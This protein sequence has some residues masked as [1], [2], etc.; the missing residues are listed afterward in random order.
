MAIDWVSVWAVVGP[1]VVG[2]GTWLKT[3]KPNQAKLDAAVSAAKAE[4]A[5]SGAA[6]AVAD[7]EGA[8]YKRLTDR[9]N[10][11]EADVSR[12]NTQLRAA[13]RH[14]WQLETIMR[15]AGMEPPP[16]EEEPV[17]AGGTD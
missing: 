8:L 3:R 14:I 12:L 13:W 16:F 7:A 10:L 11:L 15:K 2:L 5:A 4:G 1:A 9:L 17:R 6:I